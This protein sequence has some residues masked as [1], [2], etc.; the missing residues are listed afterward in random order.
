V[1]AIAASQGVKVT[2]KQGERANVIAHNITKGNL[3]QAAEDAIK[4]CI[5]HA[6]LA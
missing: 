2:A 1:L 4:V 5:G 3:R 6:K